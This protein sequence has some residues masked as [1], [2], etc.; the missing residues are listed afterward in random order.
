MDETA[1]PLEIDIEAWTPR[2]AEALYHVPA[3]GAGFFHVNEAGHVAVR[4]LGPEG[5]SIDLLEVVE[6]LR[7]QHVHP[8]VLLRF[9]D[10]LRTRVQQ[11]NRAFRRAIAETGYANTYR[12]VYPIKVNQLREVVEEILEA[13]APFS[14]GLECGSKSE[15]LATLPYLD[16]DDMLLICNGCK[17]RAMMQLILA[18]Q[19][20]GKKVIPVI[21]RMAEFRLLL[22]ALEDRSLPQ[23]GVPAIFG[24]RLRLSATGAGLWSE[25]GGETSKFG[26]SL[27]ELLG[28]L[29]HIGDGH[30]GVSLQLLHFHM[31]SQ[32]AHLAHIREAV[33][34]A[35]R[36]YARLRKRGLGITYLDIGGGLGVTYE[37]GNPDAPGSIDYSLSEYA[38]TVVATVQ[39]VCEAEGVPPPVLISE[40]GR[41][42]TAYHSVFVTE[43]LD[44]RSRHYELP[45]WAN[46]GI[47]SLLEELRRLYDAAASEP[48]SATYEQLEAVRQ[49][50]NRSFREGALSLEQKAE[51]EQLYWAT[52]ARLCERLPR[53][54]E[55]LETLPENLRQLPTRLADH[56]LCNFSVF[57]SLIDHWAIGQH[58]PIMPIH[59]LDEP[60][61]RHGIL[62]DLTCDSDGQVS[63]FVTPVGKKHT[64]E[65]HPLR[66]DEP[67][68]LGF[69]LMGAYQDIMGDQHNLFGRVTE[70]H[71][72]LDEDEP[73][74]FYIELIL[75]G[76]TVE[77]ELAQ[78]Q[79]YPN[80]LERRMNRL[81]QEKVRTGALRPREGVELLELYRRVFRT[82]TYLEP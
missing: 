82:S 70:A 34:E 52:C 53:S 23:A 19:R 62:I 35:A 78:V 25:S 39:Q 50:V 24:V 44:T 28:L 21:E 54:P 60:P 48:L 56:Y 20:L 80:D 67:Y 6:R 69:F 75:P 55:A 65:L 15:L 10:L 18:G 58:F 47:H 61:T 63:D 17:D 41:A 76:A 57:R 71:V 5:P 11:L 33:T 1:Q 79:Y 49:Q 7:A 22:E 30:S 27:S 36:I 8:P 73:G 38:H 3:W 29:D 26:L 51:A 37:A 46:G 13:G 74:N 81:I 43:V 66:P 31:G 77:K 12:G 59:R 42:L 16:R 45:A 4:P 64:L 32:I 14:F 2:A 9:Q 68:Y 40:S 72:Y